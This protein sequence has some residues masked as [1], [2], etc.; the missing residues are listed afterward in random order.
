MK[1][2][3]ITARSLLCVWTSCVCSFSFMPG[4]LLALLALG[5]V[6][7]WRVEQGTTWVTVI[8]HHTKGSSQTLARTSWFWG[9][10]LGQ[11]VVGMNDVCVLHHVWNCRGVNFDGRITTGTSKTPHCIAR[12]V[13]IKSHPRLHPHNIRVI[14]PSTMNPANQ[15]RTL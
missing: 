15:K 1:N 7:A 4:R 8:G 5:A 14:F 9:L 13:G 11:F 12:K 2:N 10:L 3:K 6:P